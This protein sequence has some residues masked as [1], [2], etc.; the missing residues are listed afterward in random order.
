MAS[1]CPRRERRREKQQKTSISIREVTS[2]RRSLQ[3]QTSLP[4]VHHK[5]PCGLVFGYSTIRKSNRSPSRPRDHAYDYR[6]RRE[7]LGD[8]TSSI[9]RS[10][11]GNDAGCIDLCCSSDSRRRQRLGRAHWLSNLR[12]RI[13]EDRIVIDALLCFFTNILHHGDSVRGEFACGCFSGKHDAVCSKARGRKQVNHCAKNRALLSVHD[14]SRSI[15]DKCHL[16]ALPEPSKTAFATSVASALVGLGFRHIDSSICQ[17][18][19]CR[20]QIATLR[21]KTI[22]STRIQRL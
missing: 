18:F 3:I 15:A 1:G 9:S 13:E 16:V 20:S 22:W 21:T 12:N 17:R 7:I 8:E 10:C 2:I 14:S 4:L 5:L 11:E 6:A 19:T